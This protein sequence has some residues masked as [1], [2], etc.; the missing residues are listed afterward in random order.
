DRYPE[1]GLRPMDDVDVLVRSEQHHEAVDALRRAGWK[2][3][4]RQGPEYSSTLAHPSIPGLPVDLHRELAIP[5]ESVFRFTSADL[6]A[7]SRTVSLFGTLTCVPSPE[8]ELL[9]LA[10][11]AGK[12]YHNFDR[13]LWAVDAAV[14]IQGAARG[15]RP[16][17][18]D[19]LEALSRRAAAR[20][21]L[22]VLLTQA[23]RLG[24]TSPPGLRRVVASGARRR[25]LDPPLSGTWP[26]ERMDRPARDRLTYAV[27][28]DPRLRVRRL[29]YEI[30]GEGLLRAPVRA[31]VLTF[32]IIRRIWRFRRGTP[33]A[34]PEPPA[35]GAGAGL[36]PPS[37]E[38]RDEQVDPVLG[39]R[40]P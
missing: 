3:T 35:P 5:A 23:E 27:I 13:L 7:A 6:W 11:H 33:H 20:S 25:A 18:W 17:D 39:D 2:A 9:L 36:S 14:V 19:A 29:G 15:E 16:I 22:A 21:A 38:E 24:A 31:A 26:L 34:P 12:P 8:A 32:R 10:T 40:E 30:V 28:D 37:A 4:R 1:P